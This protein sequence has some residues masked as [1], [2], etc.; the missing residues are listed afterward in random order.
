MPLDVRKAFGLPESCLE[1]FRAMPIFRAEPENI[2]AMLTEAHSA[3][4]HQAA[5]PNFETTLSMR[6]EML[7]LR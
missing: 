3:S 5:K 2:T 1:E 4:A 6:A 7:A